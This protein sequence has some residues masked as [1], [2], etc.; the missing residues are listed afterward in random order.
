VAASWATAERKSYFLKSRSEK[1]TVGLTALKKNAQ[2]KRACSSVRAAKQTKVF[3][4]FFS[5][6]NYFLP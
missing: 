5:K 2:A 6:K 1:V 3:W 4:F